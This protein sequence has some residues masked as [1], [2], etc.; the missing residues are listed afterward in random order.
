MRAKTFLCAEFVQPCNGSKWPWVKFIINYSNLL[1]YFTESKDN[2]SVVLSEIMKIDPEFNKHEWLR[3]CEKEIIPNILEA[4]YQMEFEVLRD[5]CYE[6][7]SFW[8]RERTKNK[9]TIVGLQHDHEC[10]QGIRK[11]RISHQR[12]AHHRCQQSGGDMIM[13]NKFIFNLF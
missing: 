3:F 2:V 6:K 10:T 8:G 9:F 11:N 5:W 12:F 13:L 1:I 7:V 4:T